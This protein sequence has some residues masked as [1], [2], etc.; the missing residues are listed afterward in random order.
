MLLNI[1]Y[2]F[3][4]HPLVW[5]LIIPIGIISVFCAYL[6]Y[7]GEVGHSVKKRYRLRLEPKDTT[8]LKMNKY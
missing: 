8:K 5:D 6:F 3:T 2:E 1:F 4:H 7:E